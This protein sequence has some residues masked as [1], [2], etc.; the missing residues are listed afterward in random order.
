MMWVYRRF[1]L[2]RSGPASAAIGFL[3][4]ATAAL[5]LAGQSQADTARFGPAFERID[6]FITLH[7]KENNTPGMSVALTTRDGL[8]RVS[9]YGWADLGAKVPV[10]PTTLFEIGSISKSFT[11]ISL[12]QLR[13]EGR[14]DPT[15]PVTAYLPWFSVHSRFRPITSHDLLTHSSGLPRDRDDV[16]S[17]L[18]QA[19]GVRDR[20]TGSPPGAHWA[21][22]NVGYQILGYLLGSLEHAPSYE[23]V[24][25]RI[26][27]PLGM[28]ATEPLITN[29]TR[30]RLAVGYTSL[31]DD[32]P[33]RASDPL[34]P[35][36]WVEYGAG[37][38]AIAS[39]PGDLAKYLRMILNRGKGPNGSILSEESFDLFT[40]RTVRSNG[41]DDSVPVYY[42]YGVSV[43]VSGGHTTITHSGGMIG[44]TSILIGD[45]EDGLGAVV[46]VNGPGEPGAVAR[47]ALRCLGAALHGDSLPEIPAADDPEKVDQAAD[48]AGVYRTTNGRSLMLTAERSGLYLTTGDQRAPLTR[49]G[50][51]KF[52][53][54]FPEFA[55]FPLRFG[56][57]STGVVELSYGGDWYVNPRYHGPTRFHY[58]KAWDGYPGH[59]RIMQPWEPNFRVVLRKGKLWWVGPEGDEE[60]LTELSPGYFRVG[61]RLSAERLRFSDTVDGKAQTANLSGMDY[62]R[63]FTP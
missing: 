27:D 48:Y 37:D 39:T 52:L 25:R 58:P 40:Q 11:A 22:S 3:L 36:T 13:Q 24:Q 1:P 41:L 6:R 8:L 23:I 2:G 59:Y 18:Y 29:D 26:L 34:V 38:G 7:M 33:T 28:T 21:Y 51:D 14:F 10:T 45:M 46:F 17:A 56:R 30:R 12:L 15:Q 9:S 32:R 54:P 43:R 62:Y 20:T 50:E 19:Y 53:T 5:P 16:P 35:G 42:G 31:Y 61:E 47:F 4:F 57:D 55:L 60:L 49:D 44:Y 63:F